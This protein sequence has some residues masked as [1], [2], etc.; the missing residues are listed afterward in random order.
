[1][2]EQT[3]GEHVPKAL[4]EVREWKGEIE[5]GVKH[6]PF[7]EAVSAIADEAHKVA[8]EFGFTPAKS[9]ALR[10]RVAEDHATYGD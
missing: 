7:G 10:L 4:R 8:A 2:T 6:L 9:P 3:K 5:A 1:M